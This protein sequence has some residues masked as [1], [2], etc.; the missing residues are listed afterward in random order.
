MLESNRDMTNASPSPARSSRALTIL[1]IAGIGVM[2]ALAYGPLLRWLAQASIHI[3]QL[4]TGALLVIFA[5]VISLQDSVRD[6]RFDPQINVA[7]VALLGLG[8]VCLAL[9]RRVPAAALPLAV[10][11]FCASFAGIIAFL[12]G[13]GGVR[14]FLPALG[15]FFVFGLLVGL[16]PRLDWPLRALAAKHA[17]SLLAG[18]GV[19]VDLA[20]EPGRPAELV[21]MV[22]GRM[23]HVATECNGFGLLTSA[24]LM[25]TILGFLYRLP[26]SSKIGL[27]MVAAPIAIVCNFLRIAA[28]CWIAPRVTWP[29]HVVHEVLG[30]VFYLAG[31]A[32]VLWTAL[33]ARPAATPALR[34]SAS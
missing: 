31:M 32:W 27:L 14:Q 34:G 23:F 22:G 20:L 12:F 33:W 3:T 11:S 24:M 15:G 28:I 9:A 5:G 21:L 8:L 10:F 19:P 13:V 4:S 26:W 6:R 16:F 18:L 30:N 7:G 29:Y 1:I 25:A 17:G 2:L